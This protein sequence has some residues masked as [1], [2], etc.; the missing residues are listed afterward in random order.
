MLPTYTSACQGSNIYQVFP[1]VVGLFCIARCT[2][3][4][5]NELRWNQRCGSPE[6][7]LAIGLVRMG[8]ALFGSLIHVGVSRC[9]QITASLTWCLVW[10]AWLVR[11]IVPPF[12]LKVNVLVCLT[13]MSLGFK[14]CSSAQLAASCSALS[15]WLFPLLTRAHQ[16][17][18]YRHTL[19]VLG[20]FLSSWVAYPDR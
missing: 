9:A 7:E 10:L 5:M 11:Q 2:L 6:A 20:C 17:D 14:F 19:S 16:N 8:S 12:Y 3:F 18:S 4:Q 1:C 13:L 15:V